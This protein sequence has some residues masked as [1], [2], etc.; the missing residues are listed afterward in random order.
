MVLRCSEAVCQKSQCQLRYV[1]EVGD[2]KSETVPRYGC[3]L[4]AS[5]LKML[6]DPSMVL[7]CSAT[8][9]SRLAAHGFMFVRSEMSKWKQSRIMTV[10]TPHLQSIEFQRMFT[11]APTL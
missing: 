5:V 11:A 4:R 6:F 2:V 8:G 9:V 1:C 3:V 7:R 10:C